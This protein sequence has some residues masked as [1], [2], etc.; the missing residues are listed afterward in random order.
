[1]LDRVR[2]SL[3]AAWRPADKGRRFEYIHT[4]D[5][6]KEDEVSKDSIEDEDLS[7]DCDKNNA[8]TDFFYKKVKLP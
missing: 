6:V 4:N 1:M 2:V 3:K 8:Q 5:S 7:L